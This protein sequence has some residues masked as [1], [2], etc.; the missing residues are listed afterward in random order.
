MKPTAKYTKKPADVREAKA[1]ALWVKMQPHIKYM[2]HG[3]GFNSKGLRL[4]RRA[5]R[6]QPDFWH[7]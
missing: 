4:A 2:G 3:L 5:E 6:L 7:F 1:E